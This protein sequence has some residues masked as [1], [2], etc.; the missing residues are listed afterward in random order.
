MATL[1]QGCRRNP[2]FFLG[3]RSCPMKTLPLSLHMSLLLI[4][5]RP[6]AASLGAR[7]PQKI[8]GPCSPVW[9]LCPH[10]L[11]RLNGPFQRD[12]GWAT[13]SS[14][15]NL[16]MCVSG[17]SVPNR[18]E[19]AGR[20]TFFLVP[21]EVAGVLLLQ[22]QIVGSHLQFVTWIFLSFKS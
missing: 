12:Q 20:A 19:P 4:Q 10:A 8:W 6:D 16:M 7:I 5:G 9:R 15:S 1:S 11:L 17:T 18:K 21:C 2:T 22:H 14:L 13:K 3:E